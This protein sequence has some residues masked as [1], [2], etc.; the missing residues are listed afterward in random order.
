MPPKLAQMVV[1]LAGQPVG[2]TIYD[3]F[4][5]TGG[6]LTEALL[7]GYKVFG[8]DVDGEVAE[9]ARKNFIWILNQM[10]GD[11]KQA[12]H[13]FQQDAMKLDKV[14]FPIDA[15]VTESYLGPVL[16]KKIP[17]DRVEMIEREI[18]PIYE[19]FLEKLLKK[20]TPQ[21]PV[22][23]CFPLFYTSREPYRMSKTL[24]KV[25][26]LGYT[27]SALIPQRIAQQYRITTT[28]QNSIIYHR[29]NQLVGREIFRLF[30]S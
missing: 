30:K 22:V 16:E 28:P 9:Q 7:M 2:K 19:L 4:C 29:E 6:I 23:I 20:I 14:S 27:A 8:S 5:G 26:E 10:N 21:T 25:W 1:N 11:L 17:I 13:I 12:K 24:A 15:I 18:G 3:P